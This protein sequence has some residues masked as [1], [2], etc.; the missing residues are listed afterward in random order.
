V[1]Y[2]LDPLAGQSFTTGSVLYLLGGSMT[3]QGM[4]MGDFAWRYDG[5]PAGVGQAISYTLSET[6]VHT[7]TMQVNA[8]GQEA[9][10][11]VA[12]TVIADT[13]GDGMPDAW[14]LAHSFNPLWAGDVNADAD[15][16]GLSNG[17]EYHLGTNPHMADTDGDG[18][19]DGAEV[20]AGTN[21]LDPNDRPAPSAR[22]IAGAESLRFTA[23]VSGA[24]EDQSLWIAN[25]AM[26][27]INWSAS[28]DSAWLKLSA[29]SGQTP[30]EVSVGVDVGELTPGVYTGAITVQSPGA[31]DSPR[32]VAVVLVISNPNS[33]QIFMPTISR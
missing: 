8:D 7:F 21:P 19:N 9:A 3:S 15:G 1:A 4:D 17:Q 10:A 20:E 11:S 33:F 27:V 13:D 23:P 6:G 12:V 30:G 2:I 32:E 26:G 25:A 18:A 24:T 28:S 14:E 31:A 16:D 22:L 29:Q 5:Q